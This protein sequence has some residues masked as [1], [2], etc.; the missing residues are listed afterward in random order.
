MS[1]EDCTS[2]HPGYFNV[3]FYSLYDATVVIGEPHAFDSVPW[4][5]RDV[6]QRFLYEKS[7]QFS[8]NWFGE[9]IKKRGA[10]KH[11]EPVCHP[12]S[13]EL[14]MK[15]MPE[16]GEWNEDWFTTWKSRRENPNNLVIF[17]KDENDEMAEISVGESS[18]IDEGS[19]QS[20]GSSH[21][22]LGDKYAAIEDS[23]GEEE[24][25][26]D[27]NNGTSATWEETLE[28]GTLCTVR[29]KIGERASRVHYDYTSLLRKSRWRKKYCPFDTFSHEN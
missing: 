15:N 1:Y 23:E 4:E 26:G 28:V 19:I 18:S 7:I 13:M 25:H 8:R 20:N 5:Y 22:D 6:K 3:D 12:K 2:N 14:P 21:D 27:V 16:P 9:I 29:L 24:D 17:D 10:D 11:H